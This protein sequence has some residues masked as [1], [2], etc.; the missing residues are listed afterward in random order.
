MGDDSPCSFD[1]ELAF[2]RYLVR[3]ALRNDKID[4]APLI[5][6]SHDSTPRMGT[7]DPA[8][9]EK[10][11]GFKNRKQQRYV[12]CLWETAM[13]LREPLELTWSK[14]DFDKRLIRLSRQ[15]VKENLDRRTPIRWELMEVLREIYQKHRVP[16]PNVLVFQHHNGN[17]MKKH[18]WGFQAGCE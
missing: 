15:D 14:I 16:S 17:P 9:Y 13:R 2:L 5:E 4:A 18:S 8:H 10:M 1:R 6:L 3:T 11:L 12:I 7:I